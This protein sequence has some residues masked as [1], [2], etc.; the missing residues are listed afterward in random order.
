MKIL[1]LNN[2]RGFQK[3]FIPFQNVNFFVG[4]NSTGKSSILSLLKLMSHPL[5]WN[6]D[7]FNITDIE[8]GFFNELVSNNLKGKKQFQIAF[9]SDPEIERP[10]K[11]IKA[12][13]ENNKGEPILTEIRLQIK[14]YNIL[15]NISQK[16]LRFQIKK[17]EYECNSLETF[18][19]W[20]DDNDFKDV[21]YNIH[22]TKDDFLPG[23]SFSSRASFYEIRSYLRKRLPGNINLSGIIRPNFLPVS[24]WIAPIRTKPKRIYESYKLT[25]SSEGDHT[26][27]LI[28]SILSNQFKKTIS[29][30][31]FAI[32]LE[33]FGKNSNLFDKI[34]IENLGKDLTSPF[35]LNVYLNGYPLKLTNVGYGVGQVLPLLAEIL[36][37]TKGRW[38]SIQ[39]PE[40]HLHPKAQAALG[41]FIFDAVKLHDQNF[42]I[43]THSDFIIDRFR[44]KIRNKKLKATTQI[45]FFERN[46][47]GNIV[48]PIP[49]DEVGQYSEIQPKS[50]RDFFINEELNLLAL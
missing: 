5:F 19:K 18:Q 38:F 41:D 12:N 48:T 46:K 44:S 27:L 36:V 49:I 8:L 39:Q 11:T 32:A 10:F 24:T 25:Y 14:N 37:A 29:K 22:S 33:K 30:E 42:L 20:I 47:N 4:E 7:D 13:Y 28:K 23:N 15:I 3:T 16:Q 34:E 31:E 45:L 26:P 6:N 35:I 50:F 9:H 43:E 21:K 40:V 2:F 17:T 1:Y